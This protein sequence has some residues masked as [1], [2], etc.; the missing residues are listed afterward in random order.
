MKCGKKKEKRNNAYPYINLSF[1]IFFLHQRQPCRN[2]SGNAGDVLLVGASKAGKPSENNRWPSGALTKF[3]VGFSTILWSLV[4]TWA[5][6]ASEDRSS[7]Q[8]VD[9]DL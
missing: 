4:F 1:S 8:M 9:C 3:E 2:P 5:A 6:F 7:R